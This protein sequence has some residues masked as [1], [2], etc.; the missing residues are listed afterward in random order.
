MLTSEQI[1]EEA[2]AYSN[3]TAEQLSEMEGE[4]LSEQLSLRLVAVE[5]LK[6]S[7]KALAQS[8][9]ELLRRVNADVLALNKEI[10]RRNAESAEERGC[11]GAQLI[12]D[13]LPNE[14]QV[15]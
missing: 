13:A 2:K 3:F 6:S 10:R 8:A 15:Y 4:A 7:K 14:A 11:D 9:N 12:L 5:E 1:V